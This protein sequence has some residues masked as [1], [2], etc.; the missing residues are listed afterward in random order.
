MFKLNFNELKKDKVCLI[1]NS[2]AILDE[3]FI[4]KNCYL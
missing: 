2:K 1:C 4:C 3:N